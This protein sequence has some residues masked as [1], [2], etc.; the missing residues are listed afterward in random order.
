[1][2][3]V[4][5]DTQGLAIV[6]ERVSAAH[7]FA[8]TYRML[9]TRRKAKLRRCTSVKNDCAT[10][11]VNSRGCVNSEPCNFSQ[12]W[13]IFQSTRARV[14]QHRLS[15]ELQERYWIGWETM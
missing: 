9:T 10:S 8:E 3:S 1:M 2:L 4:S 12:Y 5:L 13:F 7:F 11:S 15:L 14:L 6:L